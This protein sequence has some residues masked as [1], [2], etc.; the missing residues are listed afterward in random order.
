[1]VAVI[2]MAIALLQTLWHHLKQQPVGIISHVATG[3]TS[4]SIVAATA[5]GLLATRTVA[6]L[7]M[8]YAVLAC[9]T[10]MYAYWYVSQTTRRNTTTLLIILVIEVLLLYRLFRT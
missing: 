8:I 7:H 9:G 1:M 10:A 2:S 4:W 3:I 6:P 5:L